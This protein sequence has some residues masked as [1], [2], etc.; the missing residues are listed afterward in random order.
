ML[1]C[2]QCGAPMPLGYCTR[3]SCNP[4]SAPVNRLQAALTDLA[5]TIEDGS[6]RE[7]EREIQENVDL[8]SVFLGVEDRTLFESCPACGAPTR[9]AETV[10]RD[11]GGPLVITIQKMTP[12]RLTLVRGN[13]GFAGR[14]LPLPPGSFHLGEAEHGLRIAGPRQ[15]LV[16]VSCQSGGV[17]VEDFDGFGLHLPCD[18][19]AQINEDQT[20]RV[21]QQLLKFSRRP[22]GVFPDRHDDRISDREVKPSAPRLKAAPWY[23]HRLLASG[24]VGDL[25]PVGNQVSIG[26]EGADINLNDPY[27]H[28]IE[29]HLTPK[30][31][32][33]WVQPESSGNGT[34]IKAS[35]G[36][37]IP[38]GSL[39]WIGTGIYR[40][41][42]SDG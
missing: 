16:R 9:A 27:C 40:L 12:L 6:P 11:C 34:W 39:L 3:P 22:L 14:C 38:V 1:R 23:M 24:C 15:G 35:V 19:P 8:A 25:V 7:T 42:H 31:T 41:E 33:L 13:R 32:A 30:G 37:W 18:Q 5:Q 2:E 26:G 29:L 21:G 4:E 17:T 28:G 20:V 36:R 10:C